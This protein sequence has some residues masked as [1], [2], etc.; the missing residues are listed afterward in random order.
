MLAVAVGLVSPELLPGIAPPVNWIAAGLVFLGGTLAHESNTRA[1]ERTAIGGDIHALMSENFALREQV[2]NLHASMESLGKSFSEMDAGGGSNDRRELDRIVAEVR[3][4]QNLIE[5]LSALET[6]PEGTSA[7]GTAKVGAK[8]DSGAQERNAAPPRE[9]GGLYG[10]DETEVLDIVR[11]G[12]RKDRVDLYLQPV[13]SLPQRKTRFY[14]CF[15]RIRAEDGVVIRPDQYLDVA[16][17][18]GLM[19]AIDNMLLFR[20]VQLVRKVQSDQKNVGFFCNISANTLK[21]R[22]FFS[23][24]VSFMASNRELARNLIFEFSQ[25]DLDKHREEIGEYTA[26][27]GQLGFHF[28]LDRVADLTKL[29]FEVLAALGFRYIKIN[30][31]SL[32]ENSREEE[33]AEEPAMAEVDGETGVDTVPKAD[34][35]VGIDVTMLK[36]TM[37]LHG[38]DLIAEKLEEEQNLIELLDFRIDYGQGYLF[39]EPRLSK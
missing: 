22:K 29:N 37:D 31:Q 27:L 35:V 13:V 17:Q 19:G 1:T 16:K 36:R 26:R 38:I 32:L 34:T 8:D 4:L 11:E 33:V 20:C 15:S 10:L 28:S 6:K 14:E 3:V 24:F 2:S 7:P 18:A 5:R 21:D 25:T 23:D 39:G 30:A 9:A 12:L